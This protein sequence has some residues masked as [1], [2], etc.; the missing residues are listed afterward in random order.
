[1]NPVPSSNSHGNLDEEIV[2]LLQCK[3]L[4]EQEVSILIS[5]R[6]RSAIFL[7]YLPGIE[8]FVL[9]SGHL[10]RIFG[11][12]CCLKPGTGFHCL[13][14]ELHEV[15]GARVIFMGEIRCNF[16]FERE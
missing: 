15:W 5:I 10:W 12:F 9:D 6:F 2:Q 11:D 3:P 4:S 16:E 14:S 13:I 8:V 7:L 1:M